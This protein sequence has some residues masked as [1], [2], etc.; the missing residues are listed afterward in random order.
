MSIEDNTYTINEFLILN[1]FFHTHAHR[2]N[3]WNLYSCDN[4]EELKIWIVKNIK[5]Y[6]KKSG[7]N[8]LDTKYLLNKKQVSSII[9]Q[10]IDT[11]NYISETD[12][13][14]GIPGNESISKEY[15]LT[16]EGCKAFYK[17]YLDS[18]TFKD[19]EGYTFSGIQRLTTLSNDRT[20]QYMV[21]DYLNPYQFIS[22][23]AK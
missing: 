8:P 9:D 12:K 22:Y 20:Y 14:Y 4:R 7:Y 23:Y 10:L 3:N 17:N 21:D 1:E 2:G 5:S 6:F 15:R 18:S 16:D 13:K 11:Y 19:S